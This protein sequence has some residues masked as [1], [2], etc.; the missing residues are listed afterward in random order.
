MLGLAV[1]LT[2]QPVT[3]SHV[4]SFGFFCWPFI[5]HPSKKLYIFQRAFTH[6]LWTWHTLHLHAIGLLYCA[7]SGALVSILDRQLTLSILLLVGRMLKISKSSQNMAPINYKLSTRFPPRYESLSMI[8]LFNF[9]V[10]SF[11][12]DNYTG[13]GKV[14]KKCLW[15]NAKGGSRRASS[16]SIDASIT[17]TKG[18]RSRYICSLYC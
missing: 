6:K 7:L 9:K 15:R 16:T 2:F 18:G 1:V 5:H 12:N 10:N 8:L 14:S 17:Q 13:F 4:E 11:P 3:P